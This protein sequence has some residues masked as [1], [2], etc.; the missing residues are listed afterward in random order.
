MIEVD[1]KKRITAD[2][3]IK[4]PWMTTNLEKCEHGGEAHHA[5]SE[6]ILDNLKKYKGQSVLKQ[7]VLSLV[8]KQLAP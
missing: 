8:V 4:H 2:E 5:H 3:V 6:L 1:P 7:T